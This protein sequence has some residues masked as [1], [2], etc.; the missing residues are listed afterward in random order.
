MSWVRTVGRFGLFVLALFTATAK[1]PPPIRRSIREAYRI[2]VL[3][4]PI[5]LIISFFVG[6]NIALQAYNA[7]RPLGATHYVGMFV[8]IAGVRELAPIMVAALVAAKAGTEMASQISIMRIKHQIDALEVM[9]INPHWYLITPRLF[10]ILLVLPALTIIAIFTLI[11]S[12]FLVT[13]LQLNLNGAEFLALAGQS[14]QPV[15]LVYC[16]IKSIIFGTIICLISCFC[17]F[18]SANGPKGVGQATNLAVVVSAV[19]CVIFNYWFSELI[20]G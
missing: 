10:G 14:T 13:T 9:A 6:S 5:L 17:G 7:F 1:H 4:L 11:G 3:S 16:A 15:D 12:A 18:Y 19:V 8:A 20:Y 2:G